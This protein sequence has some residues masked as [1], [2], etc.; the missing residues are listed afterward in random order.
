MVTISQVTGQDFEFSQF[1]ANK[2][3]L[4]PSFAGATQQNRFITDYRNQ[5]PGL[6]QGYT[7]YSVSYDH[8]LSNFASGLGL[9]ILDDE[10]GGVNLSTVELGLLYAYDFKLNDTYHLRPGIGFDIIQ[11]SID[12]SKAVWIDQLY[13]P[14][15]ATT[16]VTPTKNSTMGFDAS[17]SGLLYNDKVW[18]GLTFDHLLQPNLTLWGENNRSPLKETLFGGITI[19]RTG[20]LLKPVDETVSIAGMFTNQGSNRQLDVGIYWAQSPLTLGFWYRGLPPFNS[21]IGD[22]LIFLVGIKIMHFSCGYSYDFTIS[23]LIT[24]GAGA[25]EFSLTYEFFHAKKKKLQ[26]VPCPEF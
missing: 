12:Y 1:Y 6:P 9:I 24:H 13:D 8:N 26:A 23:N 20:R 21:N 10:A 4:A 16:F 15:S 19:L 17:T 22:A 25:H 5:W 14:G 2:L 18:L 7:T 11:K 3:Y